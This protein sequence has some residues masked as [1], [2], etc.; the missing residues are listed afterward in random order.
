MSD[1]PLIDVASLASN[2][3]RRGWIV[4]DC[5][6]TLA[7]PAGGH[8]AYD[9][10]HIPGARYAHLD[11]DLS[12]KPSRTEGRHPLPEPI[13]F[14]AKLGAWGIGPKDTVI[15]YDE[16]SGAIA[17]RLWW[18][19]RW[20]GHERCA[21][22]DGGLAAWVGAGHDLEQRPPSVA[23]RHYPA[24]EPLA[25]LVV[26]TG[27]VAARQ[28]VGDLLVDV[29]AAPRYRGEQETIDP[30]AGHVPQARNRP[31]A[32]NV[33]PAGRFRP[34]AELRRELVELLAGRDPNRLIAMCGSGVTA[35]QLL[36]AMEVA[37]L[38]GGRL[39][40]GSWSEWIRDPARPVARGG[41][42]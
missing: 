16:G 32:S 28:A 5:R 40:A 36:L 29:R 33:T 23:A 4:V 42:P 7:D 21:V 20:I 25:R 26:S 18:L 39:Y 10:G 8:A 30:V 17:A 15:A 41:E 31:F 24:P 38:P 14:A 12:R 22:L 2:R 6:F 37:G 34:P 3:D 1:G 13:A 19:L 11:D 27:E 35:C 9:R